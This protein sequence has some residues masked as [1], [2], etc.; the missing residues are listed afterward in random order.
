MVGKVLPESPAETAGLLV[1]DLITTVNGESVKSAG[2][3]SHAIRSRESG[4]S[5]DL[6]IWRQG[7]AETVTA[8]LGE[9]DFGAR[10]A[11][12]KV[13]TICPEDD[14]DCEIEVGHYGSAFDCG[15][16]GE[17]EVRVECKDDECTCTANG[18]SIDCNELKLPHHLPGD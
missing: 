13:M 14:E 15:G 12:H 7:Y 17:C 9:S 3:L 8:V 2:R 5:V 10:H 11:M 1:G 6:G 16:A 4:E 18:D